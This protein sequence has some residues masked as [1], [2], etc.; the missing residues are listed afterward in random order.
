MNNDNLKGLY[1][2]LKREGYEPPVYEQFEKDMQDEKNLQGAYQTLKNEGYEPPAYETF[3]SDMGF[4]GD[5]SN[6]DN[7]VNGKDGSTVTQQHTQ[8]VMGQKPQNGVATQIP[9]QGSPTRGLSQHTMQQPQYSQEVY[10]RY[11]NQEVTRKGVN[12]IELKSLEDIAA[13]MEAEKAGSSKAG[14]GLISR[15]LDAFGQHDAQNAGMGLKVEAAAEPLP[16]VKQQD[17][18]QP[19]EDP[20]E[21]RYAQIVQEGNVQESPFQQMVVEL[22]GS[23]KATTPVEAQ[24]MAYDLNYR[25]ADKTGSSTVGK[26]LDTIGQPTPEMGTQIDNGWYNEGVQSEIE[27]NAKR[28]GLNYDDYVRN[29]VKPAMQRELEQ[30]YGYSEHDAKVLSGRMFENPEYVRK[31]MEYNAAGNIIGN[32][33][34]GAVRKEFSDLDRQASPLRDALDMSGESFLYAKREYNKQTDPD[35]ILSSLLDKQHSLYIDL[36]TDSRSLNQIQARADALGIGLGD[37]LDQYVAP[38]LNNAIVEKF[39]QVGIERELPKDTMDYVLG[40]FEDSVGGMLLSRMMNGATRQE[41]KN[42]ALAMTEAG[43]NPYMDGRPGLLAQGGRLATGM[44]ADFWLWGGW[45][46]IGSKATQ[47]LMKE[48]IAHLAAERGVTEAVAYRLAEEEAGH[49]L[50]KGVVNNLFKHVPQSAITMNGAEATTAA[51]QGI[52]DRQDMGTIINNTVGQGVHGAFTGT[53][54]GL[55]G[56]LMGGLTQGLTGAKR[57][58]GKLA[59]LEVEAATLYTTEELARMAN[60]EEAFDN[61]F[62]GLVESNVKLGFIKASANPVRA[63]GRLFDAVRHPVKALRAATESQHTLTDEDVADIMSSNDGRTLMDALTAMRPADNAREPGNRLGEVSVEDAEKSAAAYRD[64]MTDPDRPWIR[65]QKVAR[66]LG[67]MLPPPGLE[68]SA[69]QVNN[70]DGTWSVRTRD[71]DGQTIRLDKYDSLYDA[72]VAIDD[73]E[74]DLDT[75]RTEALRQRI[76]M[77]DAYRNYSGYLEAE[78]ETAVQKMRSGAELT[79][80]EKQVVYLHQHRGEML[81]IQNK[82]NDGEELS[83]EENRLGHIYTERFN[84]YVRRG[85]ASDAFTREWEKA[86][87]LP[88]GSVEQAIYSPE[89]DETQQRIADAY[90]EAMEERI[91]ELKTTRQERDDERTIEPIGAIEAAAQPQ[92]AEKGIDG[93]DGN[94]GSAGYLRGRAAIVNNDGGEMRRIGHEVNVADA[95]IARMFSKEEAAAIYQAVESGDEVALAAVTQ[96]QTEPAKRDAIMKLAD[97]LDAAKGMDAAFDEQTAGIEGE[98]RAEAERYQSE[99]GRIVP[100]TLSDG[101]TAFLMNG[102]PEN[103]YGTV[104]V[105]YTDEAGQVQHK[106]IAARDITSIGEAEATDAYVARRSEDLRKEQEGSFKNQIGGVDLRT[107]NTVELTMA[108]QT[109]PFRIDGFFD[110]GDLQLSDEGGE[111]MRMSRDEVIGMIRATEEKRVGEELDAEEKALKEAEKARKEAEKAEAER[112]KGVERDRRAQIE[113]IRDKVLKDSKDFK[114]GDM[115]D[116][117]V[118]GDL[119][120]MEKYLLEHF[121]SEVDA[122]AFIREQRVALRNYQRD[123]VQPKIDALQRDLDSYARSEREMTPEELS[124]VIQQH[125]QLMRQ[126]EFLNGQAQKLKDASKR[127]GKIYSG[128]VGTQGL[129]AT[130]SRSRRLLTLQKARS[131]EDKLKKA[132][133]LYAGDA[134]ASSLFDFES[135]EPKTIEEYAAEFLGTVPEQGKG[136]IDFESLQEETGHGGRRVGGDSRGYSA[137]LAP[138]GK[139]ESIK[140]LAH[141]MWERLPEQLHENWTDQDCR[142]ALIEVLSSAQVP[143]DIR[144]YILNDRIN[145]AEKYL[146]AQEEYEEELR[147]E[148]W[149]EAYH[150]P[151]GEREAYEESIHQIGEEYSSLTDDDIQKINAIFAEENELRDEQ[152]RRSQEMDRQPV[153]AGDGG[154]GPGGQGEIRPLSSETADT[155][156]QGRPDG[157]GQDVGKDEDTAAASV[158]PDSDVAGGAQGGGRG[159]YSRQGDLAQARVS[160]PLS[161]GQGNPIDAAGKLIIEK[162]DRIDDITDEDFSNPTRSIELPKIPQNVDNAIGG[163]GKPVVIKK[164]ILEKNSRDHSDLTPEQSREILFSALYNPSL[165]GQNRKTTKPHNW[166]VISTKNTEGKNRLV[167]LEVNNTKDNVEIVHWHYVRDKALE[168]IKRQAEREGGQILILPSEEEA[169]GLSSR[170]L[171]SSSVGKDTENISNLQE[172]GEKVAAKQQPAEKSASIQGIEGYDAD[173][174][175]NAVRGDIEMKLED[176]GIE[177]VTIKGMALHGSRMRGDAREDSDLDVVVEYE[178]DFSEDGLFNILNEVPTTIEGITVDINPITKGKSGTL[179]EYMER[180][181]KYDEEKTPSRPPRGEEDKGLKGF[182]ERLATAV[183]ETNTEPTE[184]QKEAGNYKKGHLSFGGYNFT[185]EN[186]KGSVRSGKD[187]SGKPWSITMHNTYGYLTGKGH[188]GKDGDH[189]DVFINDDADLDLFGNNGNNGNDEKIY[190]IDQVNADGSF[191]EH[192]IMWGFN[193]EVDAIRNY[194][195]NYSRPWHGLGNITGVDK[196]TFDKW[197]ES[198]DRKVKPFAETRFGDKRDVAAKVMGEVKRRNG[199]RFDMQGNPVDANG[200]LIIEKVER[201]EEITDTDFTN[202]TRSIELPKIPQ[203]VNDAIGA[204]GKPVIIKKNIFEKNANTH[205]FTPN[206]SRDILLSALY[207]PDLVGQTQPKTRKNHWVAIKID[208]KSPIT[209]LEVNQNKDNVE[210]VG[211]YTLDDRNLTRIKR[212]A[213]REDGELLILTPKGA[214]ASLSTLPSDLSAGKDT[215]KSSNLQGKGV[216]TFETTQS[217]RPKELADMDGS[218]LETLINRRE[219]QHSMNDLLLEKYKGKKREQLERN[220]AQIDADLEQLRGEQDRRASLGDAAGEPT[221]GYGGVVKEMVDSRYSKEAKEFPKRIQ[222]WLN[223]ENLSKARG[224][225]LDEIVEIFGN[226]PQP[227]AFVPKDALSVLGDGITDNRIYSGMG[228]FINHAVNHHPSVSAEKYDLIQ[229]VLSDPDDYKEIIRNGKRSVAFVKKIDRYNAV[230]V[231]VE[232]TPD[233]RI[234]WHKSFFDQKK[235]P[236]ANYPSIRPKDLSSGGGVSPISHSDDSTLNVD[237]SVPGSSLP[238]PDDIIS[239]GKVKEIIPNIQRKEQKNVIVSLKPEMGRAGRWVEGDLFAAAKPQPTEKDLFGTEERRNSMAKIV[240]MRPVE[241]RLDNWGLT[242]DYP[243]LQ[244]FKKDNPDALAAQDDGKGGMVFRGIDAVA[245]ENMTGLKGGTVKGVREL[246]IPSA[247]VDRYLPMLVKRG[248]RIAVIAP[249]NPP[250]KNGGGRAPSV[251]I[252][253][254]TGND[255]LRQLLESKK[256]RDAD[257]LRQL[258][259][260]KESYISQLKQG[261]PE[262]ER[263]YEEWQRAVGTKNEEKAQRA[264]ED[265]YAEHEEM[266]LAWDEAR[267]ELED[268]YGELGGKLSTAIEKK[269]KQLE[270]MSDKELLDAIGKEDSTDRYIEDVDRQDC[271]EEYDL[272]HK[273]EYDAEVESY[274]KMLDESGTEL[275][276]A[277]GMYSSASGQWAAGGY[278]S[279]E[280]TKL[281][282]QIDVLEDYIERKE[283]ERYEREMEEE[284]REEEG[285]AAAQPQPTKKEEQYEADKEAVRTHGY[286]LTGLKMRDLDEGETSQV[287]RRYVE[288]GFFSFTSGERVESAGDVAFMFRALEDAAVENSF[289]V[290]IKDGEP[291]VVHLAI[292]NYNGVMAPIEQAFVA[293]QAIDPDSVVFVH[294]HPSGALNASREDKTLQEKIEIIFGSKARP[295]II[296]DT[297]SGKYAEFSGNIATTSD[298]PQTVDKEVPVKVFSFSKQVFDKDWDPEEALKVDSSNSIAAFV[299][300]HRLGEHPKMSLIV[301]N[302][303]MRVTGNIFLPWTKLEDACSRESLLRMATYV[304]QMGGNQAVV[305]GDFL[306]GENSGRLLRGLSTNLKGF[307]V[308]LLDVMNFEN[309]SAYE[310]GVIAMEPEMEYKGSAKEMMEAVGK[311]YHGK[312]MVFLNK[313]HGEEQIL[314]D[315]GLYDEAA[316]LKG[317]PKY[318]AIMK[319]FRKNLEKTVASY[320]RDTKKIYIFAPDMTSSKAEEVFFHENIHAI[321]DDW[322]GGGKRGIADRFWD[323]MPDDGKVS[324]T[325]VKEKSSDESEYAEE[326]FAYWLSRSMQDGDVSDFLNY[327]DDADKKRINNILK[328]LDYDTEEESGRRVRLRRNQHVSEAQSGYSETH[329]GTGGKASG[330]AAEEGLTDAASE[331]LPAENTEFSIRQEAAPRKTGIGYKVFVLKDGKLYPPMVANPGGEDTPVGV[332]LNADAAP[333]SGTSKTGRPQV[334]AGGKGTQGGSGQLAYRPGWHLGVIPYALQFGRKDPVTGERILFP[335]NFVWAE[336]EY[337]ND[338]DY[339]EEARQEGIN[340]N[341]KYQ[342][343]LAGLKHLPVDGSYMYRTNPDPNTDPWIITGAMRVKRVL[344]PS[345]VDELV[346]AAGREPQKRQEGFVTDE[347]VEN[348]NKAITLQ[349]DKEREAHELATKAV[350]QILGKSG[351]KYHEVSQEEAQDVLKNAQANGGVS[352]SRGKKRAMETASV[353]QDEEHQHAVISFADGAKIRNNLETLAKNLE[354]VS[355]QRKNFIQ[356][357]AKAIDATQNGSKSEYS[358]FET[359][360]GHIVTIRLSDHNA[361]VSNYDH[362]NE[363]DG[364]SIVVSPK[365]SNG[366]TNDGIAHVVEY[367]YDP[368]KLRKAEGKPL[369][370]IVKSIKQVLYSGVYKDRTGLAEREEVNV[371]MDFMVGQPGSGAPVFVSN[372]LKAVEGIKQEKATPEQWL[373]MIEKNGGLKAGEDKWMG[374]S[375]WLNQRKTAGHGGSITK[376]EVL[377]F[378]RENQIQVEEVNYN[379][380]IDLDNNSNMKQFREEFD[381]FVEK[382]KNEKEAVDAEM[383]GFNDEMYG[384]YGEGWAGKLSSTDKERGEELQARYNRLTDGDPKELAFN[385]MV[386]KYGDDFGM[387]FEINYGNGKLDAQ[388]DMY[389]DDISDAA[390]YFLQFEEQPINSTRLSYTTNGLENKREIALTVPTVESWNE[391]DEIHFGDAGGGRAVAWVRFGETTV[392]KKE[393]VI[394]VVKDFEEPYKN[395]KGMLVYYPKGEKFTGKDY[396]VYGKSKD[397]KMVYVPIMN[398]EQVAAFDTLDEARNAMNEWYKSHNVG[399]TQYEKVLVIDEIQSKRHQEGRE[400][401]YSNGEEKKRYQETLDAFQNFNREMR[402]KYGENTIPSQWPKD[403]QEEFG[404]LRDE[405]SAVYDALR[406]K[407]NTIPDAPFEKNWHELAMKR[408]LRYAA[409]NGYDKVAWTK[410][411]QQAERYG[412]GKVVDAIEVNPN[413]DGRNMFVHQTDGT[414]WEMSVDNEG[415]IDS[416]SNLFNGK[417]VME[418]FGKEIGSKIMDATSVLRLD[419]ESLRVGGEGMKGFYDQMLPRFMDKY[420]KKWGVKT[421]EVK[422]PNVQAE[423]NPSGTVATMWAV[424]VTPEMRE[425]VMQGQPMFSAGGKEPLVTS[426]GVVYG[427]TDGED[428]YLTP[429]G[430]N[431]ETP[432]HEYGHLW[433]KAVKKNR[434]DLWENIK[435]LM[436]VD[437]HSQK[438]YQKLLGDENYSQIHDN[439]DKLYEEVLTQMGGRKNRERFEQAAREVI[440]EAPTAAEAVK[441]ANV[442]SRIRR[443]FRKLWDWVGKS[444][445]QIKK[446]RSVDEV[447]DRMMYD[448]VEGNLAAAKPLPAEKEAAQPEFQV[449]KGKPRKMKGEGMAHYFERLREWDQREKAKKDAAEDG[450]MEPS[451]EQAD[452]KAHADWARD[453]AEWERNPDGKAEPMEWDYSQKAE[454]EYREALQAYEKKIDGYMPERTPELTKEDVIVERE[455]QV[456]TPAQKLMN[457]ISEHLAREYDPYTAS[458]AVKDAVIQRRK[459]IEEISADDSIYIE[460]IRRE[461]D[462]LAD[463]LMAKMGVD[464]AR[465]KT[466]KLLQTMSDGKVKPQVTGADIR[467]ALSYFI[468]APMRRRDLANEANEALEHLGYPARFTADNIKRAEKELDAIRDEAQELLALHKEMAEDGRT[469][470]TVEEQGLYGRVREGARKVADAMN[471]GGAAAEPQPT[472]KGPRIGAD[473]VMA[474]LSILTKRV[475]PEGLKVSE[476]MPEL[477]PIIGKAKDWYAVAYGWLEDAGMRP[478]DIGYYKDYVNHVWDKERSDPEAY[479]RY[480]DVANRQPTKSRNMRKREIRT[481]M[482]GEELGL[483][484]KYDD[485][486]D[487]MGE[488]S[489]TNI[490]SW[491]NKKMLVDLSGIDVVERDDS[492]EPTSM[493]SLLTSRTPGVFDMDKYD[494]FEIAGVGPVWVHKAASK[495][496]GLVFETYEPGKIAKFYDQA[497]SIAKNIELAWSGFHAAALTEVYAAQNVIRPKR[498]MQNFYKYLI[499]DSLLQGQPPAYADPE[500]YKDAARHLV[501]LGATGDYAP[502]AMK[503]VSEQLKDFFG[504]LRMDMEENGGLGKAVGMAVGIPEVVATAVKLVNEGMDK[505]LWT[506]LHDGLKLCQYKMFRED[507]MAKAEKEGWSQDRINKALDEA[508][509]YINDEFGGQHFEVIGVSPK[510]LRKMRRFLLSPDWLLSTQRHFL[511]TFG[512]GSIYNKANVRNF[513]DFYRNVWHRGKGNEGQYDGRY[514]RAK[515]SLACYVLGCMIMY[516][517]VMNA[518]NALLRKK[519]EEYEAQ[520]EQENPGYVSKY[521]LAYP[522]GMKGF[523]VDNLS[524]NPFNSFNIFGDYGMGSN[525]EGKKSHLFAGRYGD[526]TEMYIRWGKQFREFPELFENEQ[527]EVAFPAPLVKRLMGKSNPN[528]RWFYYTVNYYERWDKSIS[529][530]DLEA[531]WKAWIGDGKFQ[532]NIG[533]PSG[534]GAN[535]LWQNYL[536]FWVPRQ[537][538][539]EWKPT[540]MILPSTKGFTPYKARNYFMEFIK[541]G[542]EDGIKETFKASV[543][544]GMTSAQI[545]RA[546][547]AAR[548]AVEN[549]SRELQLKDGNNIHSVTEAFD[550]SQDLKERK[551]LNSRIRKMLAADAEP[552][553]DWNEFMT[554]VR[555]ERDGTTEG[556]TKA[557]EKYLMVATSA[558]VLEDARLAQLKKKASEMKRI[559]DG[560]KDNKADGRLLRQWEQQNQK[561]LDAGKMIKDGESGSESKQGIL[562]WKKQM[563]GKEAND[564]KALEM[565]RKKRKSLLKAVGERVK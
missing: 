193:S 137:Y 406:N 85:S 531:K 331:P 159:D 328:T 300:S 317:T 335:N 265:Y 43:E 507:V 226:D 259:R 111:A 462:R 557:S 83:E 28:L 386:E 360:N 349:R 269:Q 396:I 12:D 175:L 373:K 86:N 37:Y 132:R 169:G 442:I 163:D 196:A 277:Y 429:E 4:G 516:P 404:R 439:E 434:P 417:N 470:M 283:D 505:A 315:L 506:W 61:P 436:R 74:R 304:N 104:N 334:K 53:A 3:R 351:V 361:T 232:K 515:A 106:Q 38:Q 45:G 92:P 500:L 466:V 40:G 552:P 413:K 36:L 427:Y 81:D 370:D 202:P 440:D 21:K 402:Q 207:N 90:R 32:F 357:V 558:D 437:E 119:G 332:W 457:D 113:E 145:Q 128:K 197:V 411:E 105:A 460:G 287:E 474:T 173:E 235:E 274:M 153:A 390:K 6:G 120:E 513:R 178:G 305:Y 67:G 98:V 27:A 489:K 109:A 116:M 354:K 541:A 199:L 241:P 257:Y 537:S 254:D 563:T 542:D 161:D 77:Y 559:H 309:R 364:I 69:E 365:K 395:F 555:A 295:G 321:L 448:F 320:N 425:S 485:I 162:V 293:A 231:E 251:S 240:S 525:A 229:D 276:E 420:G 341:G 68:V 255:S 463:E 445:F 212:Q 438:V 134:E 123:E 518:L 472:E 336:V 281:R 476:D 499:H 93:V 125:T 8:P 297:K 483:V 481:L 490:Q 275:D 477:Q 355:N 108:G 291:T 58:L 544:N 65:K 82:L 375:E 217:W 282:A 372:A 496:F 49:Y 186:P 431:P 270:G 19:L 408:M 312:E 75:N 484:P 508:G 73:M 356:E 182:K 527:G 465:L 214:A 403:V 18:Q 228:Y 95:R 451:R 428:I 210:V 514:S 165:Y 211:W 380:H 473:D 450:I 517:L 344:K 94:N 50:K 124:A 227:V 333:V 561:W 9:E 467:R 551:E 491:A 188:L 242:G 264:Y 526:D 14:N 444:L 419:G 191:D 423:G 326:A 143:T 11:D 208:E 57:L 189:L 493:M 524:L 46:K 110:N 488:Y 378:I 15:A 246:T 66:L 55:T 407:P 306:V 220:N 171:G 39:R 498:A 324:K 443:A 409:E 303:Q 374:L 530:E 397:G 322:Y 135:M 298:R 461:T 154:E 310:S 501:K 72:D 224:K 166:V 78:Y 394:K 539:K 363:F 60:G 215:K 112:L 441:V 384:K 510:T 459:D 519:D 234:I 494:Y 247:N 129:D 151:A 553:Q 177:G 238:T 435:D 327:F 292:G 400:K 359:K 432:A 230:V 84:D 88:E 393:K 560:M 218:H 455:M 141:K 216:K 209:V 47:Q 24:Q 139:G 454:K 502:E 236:Y 546:F 391:D 138:K 272:R 204:E 200:K 405:N 547:D 244:S 401:G 131:Y 294:N 31:Q 219:S 278:H 266:I 299:S 550:A 447:T 20:L 160:V 42:E 54:F 203:N 329:Q 495:N 424:D 554:A 79:D 80:G 279:D 158:V 205:Q 101:S 345:E 290:L 538:D 48:R 248:K 142:N 7:G 56:G 263:L 523:E 260:Q 449:G 44:A 562:F 206:E 121:D 222:D 536:P 387:A 347:Q 187:A 87:G 152:D 480:V 352:L 140:A 185:V 250:V 103:E 280:R 532:R 23:G 342:H 486:A 289:M 453:H 350:I 25:Y 296:I 399:E 392:P 314:K 13:E 339:Q 343:S 385:E 59:G 70:G 156:D 91:E 122:D 213:E 29:H 358:T 520:M 155:Q 503:Q 521:K 366:I 509:Q 362:R 76:D 64:F 534:V 479:K 253:G 389:G 433:V 130:D 511:A 268:L 273:E 504:E 414:M 540:D 237:K 311:R 543:L 313:T 221:H 5:G 96:Q 41:F 338:V 239:E 225:K 565:I 261:I 383:V 115:G 330:G 34:D 168:T 107:G 170:T 412:I 149:A 285:A 258:I 256:N 267:N 416:D 62:E 252:K 452:A 369:S 533:I 469:E 379:E 302:N 150:I 136:I 301:L 288:N 164:N 194:L 114:D 371:P 368:I 307:N 22:L 430:I 421:G 198:S 262:E 97:A 487:L 148:E 456:K 30:R 382:F 422:L 26:L 478:E 63:I 181:R 346:K 180:S 223:E 146:R 184:G 233:G 51:V 548:K 176:A 179:E 367:Y 133:E 475:K 468:E 100:L 340:A 195:M 144:D 89:R 492:G 117:G 2:T 381:D 245:V 249:E 464:G 458:D 549:E 201:I 318:E 353:S 147:M 512:F 316:G 1:E 127:V 410:G 522:E 545:S 118:M 172:N 286:D 167:L 10:D 415:T 99:D 388:M 426:E 52:R 192:K 528:I 398:H 446:F 71:Y 323:V 33:M 325:Y 376:Q 284:E 35:K 348:L 17:T 535:K 190:I 157:D 418:V 243:Y 529:D 308:R 497:A 337:A 564:R 471:G 16:A 126:Q 556:V 377:D 174:V 102:D 183:E 319:D 271:I 482:D